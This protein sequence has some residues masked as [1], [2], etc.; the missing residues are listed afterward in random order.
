MVVVIIIILI[1]KIGKE[2]GWE[3]WD[4]VQC[5]SSIYKALGSISSTA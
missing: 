2:T 1:N 5:L 4:V 3:A